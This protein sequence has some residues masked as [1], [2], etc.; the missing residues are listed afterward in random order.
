MIHIASACGICDLSSY[1]IVAIM[2]QIVDQL[3]QLRQ[4]DLQIANR[5][6][7]LLA[8][9]NTMYDSQ[10]LHLA[11]NRCSGVVAGFDRLD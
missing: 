1:Y 6:A 8:E 7:T 11:R 10:L 3:E 5:L 4:D 9:R 2:S